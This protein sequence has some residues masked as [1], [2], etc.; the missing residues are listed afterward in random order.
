[1]VNAVF[2]LF[3]Q[4]CIGIVALLGLRKWIKK[5]DLEIDD[6]ATPRLTDP[7]EIAYLRK[8]EVETIKVI[9]ISLIDR[10]LLR[11]EDDNL[12]AQ[13]SSSI[14]FANRPIEK[15]VLQYFEQSRHCFDVFQ[16]KKVRDVCNEYKQTLA[17]RKLIADTLHYKTRLPGLL[18]ASAMVIL[19]YVICVSFNLLPTKLW[20]V[21]NM[22]VMVFF[23]VLLFKQYRKHLTARGEKVIRDLRFLFSRLQN[24]AKFLVPG[25]NTNEVAL[26]IA[27][28]G[29]NILPARSFPFVNKLYADSISSL[30]INI[31]SSD[32]SG[33]SSSCS[34]SC[35]GGCGGD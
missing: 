29:I 19:F 3:V 7:Y 4:L 17:S 30:E 31:N 24:R 28:F 23:C 18:I 26:A 20:I 1:M 16:D 2:L 27:I 34:N 10:K 35:S 32:D 6:R 5:K 21:A 25:G 33:S 12:E 15:A 14:E 13:D 22:L 11:Y 8:G 9:T